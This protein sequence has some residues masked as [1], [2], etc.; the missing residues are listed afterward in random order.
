MTGMVEMTRAMRTAIMGTRENCDRFS[1]RM[2]GSRVSC[3]L[4]RGSDGRV[5]RDR[6]HSTDLDSH[7]VDVIPGA[8]TSHRELKSHTVVQLRECFPP[9]LRRSRIL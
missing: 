5:S 2:D 1:T 7:P 6:V 4:I 8:I 3:G 9:S